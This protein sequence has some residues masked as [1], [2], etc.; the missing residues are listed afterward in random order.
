MKEEGSAYEGFV[1][2]HMYS[3]QIF[4]KD[5]GGSEQQQHESGER[6]DSDIGQET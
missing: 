2:F 1:Q 5:K 3:I 6:N 4:N